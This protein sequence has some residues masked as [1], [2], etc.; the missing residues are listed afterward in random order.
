MFDR[1]LNTPLLVTELRPV[2]NSNRAKTQ[3]HA[4]ANPVK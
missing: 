3:A 2:N 4:G 1:V